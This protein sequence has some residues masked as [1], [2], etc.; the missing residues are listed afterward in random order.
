MSFFQKSFLVGAHRGASM[1]CPENTL[2]SFRRAMN[3]GAD[4]IEFDVQQSKDKK[5]IV[6]HDE[7]TFRTTGVKG[8]IKEMTLKQIRQLD[9]GEGEQIPTLNDL[10]ELTRGKIGLNCEIKVEGIVDQVL[11]E[12][13]KAEMLDTVLIS[14][15]LHG[16][17]I[18]VK[19]KESCIRI[20]SLEPT[21]SSIKFTKQNKEEMLTFVEKNNF[22]AINPLYSLVNKEFVETAHAKN[23]KMFPW[24]VD[25]KIG[26]K[27][28]LK[29]GVDGIMTN[30]VELL[31][32]LVKDFK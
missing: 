17:L 9:A 3:L 31:I 2:K 12:F 28:L 8:K 23:I 29:L 21:E 24:T 26:M 7:D 6:I 18:E 25:T 32:K 10:I 14:S 4:F 16:E 13:G 15:F 27:R 19:K 22:Y 30:D 5:L 1:L 11:D 20:G